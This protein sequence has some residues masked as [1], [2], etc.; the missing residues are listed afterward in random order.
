[1]EIT[2]NRTDAYK[3]IYDKH[4]SADEYGVF[5]AYSDKQL[6]EGLSKFGYEKSDIVRVDAQ[7]L[8]LYGPR[9]KCLA[10]LGEYEKRAE[11]V[12]KECNPQDIYDYEFDNHECG[13]TGDDMEVMELIEDIFGLDA[14]RSVKRRWRVEE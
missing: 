6:S 4:P 9:E 13:Y 10:F 1:M 14:A 7:G 2:M 8:G 3:G 12:K 11:R 5:F